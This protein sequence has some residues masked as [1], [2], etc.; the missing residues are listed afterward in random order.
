[1]GCLSMLQLNKDDN[2]RSQLQLQRVIEA[3]LLILVIAWSGWRGY[4]NSTIIVVEFEIVR[5]RKNSNYFR[6]S[7]SFST[8]HNHNQLQR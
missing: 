1:M 4:S 8:F 7:H 2:P 6:R 5:T 3:L